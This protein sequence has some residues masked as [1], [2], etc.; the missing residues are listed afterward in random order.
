M[1]SV[2]TDLLVGDPPELSVTALGMEAEALGYDGLWLTELW[3]ESSVVRLS[4]L[5]VRTGEI[6]LGTAVVNVFSRSPATL[7]MT[8]A[9]LDR[10]S[11][12]RFRLG[13][14]TS[15]E[16]VIEGLHGMDWNDPNPVRRAH[17]TIE[18][19]GALL[20]AD[21]PVEYEGETFTVRDVQPLDREV[22]V[23]YAALGKGNRRV[24]A[25]L[26]D[27]WIP[28]NVPVPDLGAHYEYVESR[29]E[30]AG[31]DV[32]LDVAP[33]VP[34]AVSDDPAAARDAIRTHIASSVGTGPATGG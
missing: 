29:M 9:A 7:A 15:T 5:A 8:A 10:L 34:A 23:Y 13:L 30:E 22:P 1:S 11:G 3:G 33:V 14:G 25:R 28:H 21:G 6:E 27:G 17:E 20:E 4:E 32:D 26:C 19:V 16:Q 24:V 31:R 18:L 2:P 12:G